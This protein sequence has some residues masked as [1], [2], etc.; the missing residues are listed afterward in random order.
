VYCIYFLPFSGVKIDLYPE[1]NT[2]VFGFHRYGQPSLV[3]VSVLFDEINTVND[4]EENIVN[5]E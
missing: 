2:P 3:K 5:W 1:Y 4:P